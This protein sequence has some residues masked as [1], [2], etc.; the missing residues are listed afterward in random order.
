[1]SW[2]K[3]EVKFLKTILLVLQVRE[4]RLQNKAANFK[5]T[6]FYS[7]DPDFRLLGDYIRFLLA[8]RNILV[9]RME[10]PLGSSLFSQQTS[11]D[12]WWSDSSL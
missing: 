6:T 3:S 10:V 7:F 11:D 4:D 8:A 1:M 12:V 5:S 2:P 9:T